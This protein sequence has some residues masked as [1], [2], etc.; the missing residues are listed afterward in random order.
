MRMLPTRD[1]ETVGFGSMDP[2]AKELLSTAL[3]ATVT[4]GEEAGWVPH[5][6]LHTSPQNIG[7]SPENDRDRAVKPVLLNSSVT[8]RAILVM[9]LLHSLL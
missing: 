5:V 3:R 6:L 1:R 7:P 2:V 9:D 8:H 4:S